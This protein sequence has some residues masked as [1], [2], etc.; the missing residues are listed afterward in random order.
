MAKHASADRTVTTVAELSG[1]EAVEQ[2]SVML[3]GMKV[4]EV[5]R[6]HAR[7]LLT[8][9]RSLFSGK[10]RDATASTATGANQ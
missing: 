6:K 4:T 2:I 9:A 1:K 8:T 10:E 5:T 7:E 3:G